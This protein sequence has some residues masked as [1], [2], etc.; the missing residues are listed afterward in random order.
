MKQVAIRDD[1]RKVWDVAPHGDAVVYIAGVRGIEGLLLVN[2]EHLTALDIPSGSSVLSARLIPSE[3]C[4]YVEAVVRTGSSVTTVIWKEGIIH[5]VFPEGFTPSFCGLIEES[6][7]CILNSGTGGG[8]VSK[9]GENS[10]L[11][12]G[13]VTI[14]KNPA[15]LVN[16][17]LTI[18]LSST[19]G[20]FPAIWREGEEQ[21]L[22]INGFISSVSSFGALP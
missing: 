14:G 3:D 22:K 19:M 5:Q 9:D 8:I 4:F 13:Y 2:G 12:A 10:A 15:A 17:I 1:I 21:T 7:C 20:G 11:P 6:L 18:G 16:G